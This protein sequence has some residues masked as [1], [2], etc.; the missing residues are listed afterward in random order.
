MNERR[1]DYRGGRVGW[2]PRC[3]PGAVL[4]TGL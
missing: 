4:V 3:V 2:D 1:G